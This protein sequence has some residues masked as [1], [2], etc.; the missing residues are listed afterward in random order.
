MANL[1]AGRAPTSKAEVNNLAGQLP[2]TLYANLQQIR[3]FKTWLDSKTDADLL[4][5][6]FSFT[7]PEIDVIKSTFVD[8]LQLAQIHDG[9][10]TLGTAK[11]FNAFAKQIRAPVT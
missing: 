11:D 9:L 6:P 1:I 4:A 7:Q 8:L 10:A 5:A 2:T 3:Q